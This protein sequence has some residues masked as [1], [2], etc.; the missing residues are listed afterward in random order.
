MIFD[1]RKQLVLSERTIRCRRTGVRITNRLELDENSV[2]PVVEYI[3]MEASQV[4]E[5]TGSAIRAV[6]NGARS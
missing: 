3:T 5:R 6:L 1:K 2:P 4:D